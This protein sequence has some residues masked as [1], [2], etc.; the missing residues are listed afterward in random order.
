MRRWVSARHRLPSAPRGG[1]G[2]REVGRMPP[3]QL[4]LIACCL[5]RDWTDAE[6]RLW[7]ARRAKCS[8]WKFSRQLPIGHRVADFACPA[9]KLVIAIDGGWHAAGGPPMPR[10]PGALEEAPTLC[11][12]N[13]AECRCQ[14]I[15]GIR[16]PGAAWRPSPPRY[17]KPRVS[18]V[19]RPSL[20]NPEQLRGS[21]PHH[22]AGTEEWHRSPLRW[23]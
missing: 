8:P 16:S 17:C 22:K 18:K 10:G 7:H 13:L 21:N 15:G 5:R 20:R 1:E 6:Q 11:L 4:T 14:G 12:A 2:R 19:P 3:R 9:R 23:E